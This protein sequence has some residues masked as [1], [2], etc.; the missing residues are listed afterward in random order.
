MRYNSCPRQPGSGRPKA[1]AFALAGAALLAF[2]GGA[3]AQTGGPTGSSTGSGSQKSGTGSI[4]TAT[5]SS[6][7]GSTGSST[8]SN[9]GSGQGTG[10]LFTPADPIEEALFQLLVEDLTAEFPGATT[11]EINLVAELIFDAYLEFLFGTPMSGG[12]QG[13][14]SQTGGSGTGSGQTGSGQT[15]SSQSGSGQTG[16]QSGSC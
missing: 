16:G 11:D 13:T 4:G 1:L 8:G 5:G 7:G 9:G 3:S 12:G 6:T 14:G 2:A 10:G 15:G